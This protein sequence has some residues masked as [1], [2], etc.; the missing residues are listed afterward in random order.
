M[1]VRV[2]LAWEEGADRSVALPD[3]ATAGA[4]GAD[5]RANLPMNLRE[6]GLTLDPLERLIVPTG[7]RIEIPP[8]SRSR[9]GPARALR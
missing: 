2:G 4:A 5:I 7:F 9:S 8:V 1:T 3:Y 6:V